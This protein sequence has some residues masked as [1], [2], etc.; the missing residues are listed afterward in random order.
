MIEGSYDALGEVIAQRE[1]TVVGDEQRKVTVRMGKPRPLS[2]LT[3]NGSPNESFCPVQIVG[4]GEQRV[5]RPRGIDAFEA[6]QYAIQVISLE[7]SHI[8]ASCGIKLR[9]KSGNRGD[10]GFPKR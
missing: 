4:I 6:V 5:I 2:E 7:L 1:F 3:P 9:W 8:E 10:L